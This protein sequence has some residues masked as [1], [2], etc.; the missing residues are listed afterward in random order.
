MEPEGPGFPREP[1][2]GPHPEAVASVHALK[3]TW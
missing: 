3:A 2:T 1:A